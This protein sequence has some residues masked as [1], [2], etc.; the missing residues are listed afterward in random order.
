MSFLSYRTPPK[1]SDK[2]ALDLK[3]T[4]V[5]DSTFSIG[6]NWL[7]KNRFGIWEAKLTGLPFEIGA[8]Y[9]ILAKEL[10][11]D[12][13]IIF[14]NE[15]SKAV[16][17]KFKQ[18]FLKHLIG[19]FNRKLDKHIPLEYLLEIYGG[20]FANS[21]KFNSIAPAYLRVL[22]YHAAHDIGHAL[23]DY[24]LVGCTS[25]SVRGSK[26]ED[27]QIISGRN[28][29]FYSG[30][31]F[32]KTKVISFV[33][34]KE[35][36][37]FASLSW[38]GFSGVVSGMNVK[39]IT[40]TMNAAKSTLPRSSKT[41]ISLLGRELLQ[42]ASNL[43]EAIAIANKRDVFVSE[44]IM[45]NSAPDNATVLIE[46]APKQ[47]D[48]FTT[49]SDTIICANHFQ[50]ELFA[51]S[52]LNLGNIDQSDSIYRFNKM[53][54]LIDES[55]DINSEKAAQ[56]LRD[57]TGTNGNDLGNGNPRAINQLIAHHSV[58]FQP[59][60]LKMWI[61]TEPWQV[62]EYICYDLNKVF[63]LNG[64]PNQD[65]DEQPL[66][67][68]SDPFL[69]TKEYQ[70]FLKFRKF[71]FQLNEFIYNRSDFSLDEQSEEEFINSN[72]EYYEGYMIL[73]MYFK[74]LK[75]YD[76]AKRYFKLALEKIVSS[77]EEEEKI[78]DLITKCK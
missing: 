45:V 49:S 25:F 57:R 53:K 62:G 37:K 33:E 23:N 73:G 24:Q 35:G 14:V 11:Q 69:E 63:E 59:G 4:T 5:S 46:K 76:K 60:Q 15:F 71:K 20:S 6:D 48:K 78:K 39:G 13:E 22:N 32:A 66:E 34:P 21:R 30:D 68:A 31:E 41:P 38:P 75:R 61:S 58:I 44:T 72:P 55:K 7:R 12:Q 8:K 29:D 27:G 56:I 52:D 51:Q 18:F 50:S 65:I 40:V 70:D 3:R 10:I 1:V 43:D 19:L 2:S 16:P 17:R 77:K 9:G 36:H 54:Q 28:F 67:I 42:Y 26:T 64:V 74:K 47:S